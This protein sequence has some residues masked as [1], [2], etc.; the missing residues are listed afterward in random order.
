LSKD[1]NTDEMAY[2]FEDASPY[3]QRAVVVAEYAEILKESYWAEESTLSNVYR[4]A[5]RVLELLPF[6]EAMSE[7]V[8]LVRQARR[9]AD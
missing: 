4:E 7:F 3:F 6:D 9:L 5:E 2:R 8:E 1:F